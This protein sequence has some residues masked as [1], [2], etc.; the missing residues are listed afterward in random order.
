[1]AG[2]AEAVAAVAGG[3]AGQSGYAGG[4]AEGALSTA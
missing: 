2:V 1:L 4:Y 3:G